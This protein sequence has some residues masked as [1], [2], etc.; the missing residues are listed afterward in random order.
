MFQLVG[1]IAYKLRAENIISVI[2][3]SFKT[4]VCKLPHHGM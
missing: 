2:V 4:G 1:L 3:S